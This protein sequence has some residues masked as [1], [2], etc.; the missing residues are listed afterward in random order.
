MRGGGEVGQ[1][2][3]DRQHQVGLAGQGVGRGG[4]LQADAADL[5]PGPLLYRA[6][7]GE[8]LQHREA[9]RPGQA[10]ELGGGAG[11]DD[12]AARDDQRPYRGS[13]HREHGVDLARVG[14]RAADNPGPFGKKLSRIVV[15]VG[16][17]VLRQREHHG[18]GVYR[19]GEHPHGRGQRGEQLFGPGDAVEEAADRPERVVD[20]HVRLERV[21]QLLQHRA[22]VPGRVRVAGQ[23]QYRQ[24]VDGGQRRPGHHVQRARADRG[25]HGQSG[26]PAAVLGE[27]R[28]RVYQGLLV[29]AL[30]E[31]HGV[32]ELVQGLAEPGH[33]AMAEDA[34]G[35]GDQPAA[36][37]VGDGVLP[38]QVRHDGLGYRQPNGLG[39]HGRSFLL[40]Q[41]LPCRITVLTSVISATA[42]RGPS[43][44]MPLAFS[45][46]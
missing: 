2:G 25:G 37:A 9:G 15:G 12:P 7:A 11:V 18:A 31:R 45:P 5:P 14:L 44:P 43:L 30:N 17:D 27:R 20:G 4:A 8:G 36:L 21:L 40:H 23:Q 6:L 34:Q 13:Q 3:P 26:A 22:L 32:A 41:G 39:G 16:L 38:G 10:L 29:A 19:V 24:P 28:G 33:V 35:G 42:E 1:P 46:P